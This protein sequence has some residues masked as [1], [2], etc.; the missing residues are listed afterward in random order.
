MI[1]LGEEPNTYM[2]DLRES[3]EE[4]SYVYIFTNQMKTQVSKLINA[5]GFESMLLHYSITQDNMVDTPK[6]TSA[7]EAWNNLYADVISKR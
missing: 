2:N 6:F 5:R 1:C 3:F 7:S 4:K